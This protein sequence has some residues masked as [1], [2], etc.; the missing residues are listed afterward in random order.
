MGKRGSGKCVVHCQAG[1]NR[2]VLIVAAY[3]MMET[4]TPVLETV[5]H[6][7]KQRGNLAL[8]N[9]GFQQQLVAMA[10]K[11]DL[12]GPPPG[13][14]GSALQEQV[15]QCPENEWMFAATTAKRK[16]NPLDRLSPR[17]DFSGCCI[18]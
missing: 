9:E 15:P 8:C 17:H 18:S 7:R 13:T 12:L 2:S 6:V 11:R 14:E 1:L 3:Y 5:R 10:R 4:R 16:E